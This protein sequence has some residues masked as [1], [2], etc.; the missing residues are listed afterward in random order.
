M[1]C[2]DDMEEWIKIITSVIA[3]IGLFISIRKWLDFESGRL[4]NQWSKASDFAYE[5]FKRTNDHAL[6][7]TSF[8]LGYAALTGDIRLTPIQRKRLLTASDSAKDLR[9]YKRCSKMISVTEHGY[10]LFE[11][12]HSRYE[13]KKYRM[14]IKV[15]S[16]LIYLAACVPTV[17]P[18]YY[19]SLF[20]DRIIE[21]LESLPLTSTIIITLSYCIPCLF[22]A[23][24][25]LA[26]GIQVSISE[27]LIE[28]NTLSD[29]LD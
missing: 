3:F 29:V 21:K 16:Y 17:L 13:N 12:S 23:V 26:K 1:L 20:S 24:I 11:W 5:L 28:K 6:E 14:F 4:F 18:I 22:I 19:S 8:N 9:Q 27:E 10:S 7:K 25:S 2:G 15:G